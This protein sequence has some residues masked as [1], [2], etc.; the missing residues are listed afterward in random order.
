MSPV[1]TLRR[2]HRIILAV[3]DAAEYE[4][5][6][7]ARR[8]AF[9]AAVVG[10]L[11]EFLG[12]FAHALH[13]AKEERHLFVHLGR[14]IAPAGRI[15]LVPLLRCHDECR[16][17]L[18]AVADLLGPSIQGDYWTAL[19]LSDQIKGYCKH[20]RAHIDHEET[21]VF[22]AAE[23]V[24]APLD[25][26]ALTREFQAFSHR[27]GIDAVHKYRRLARDL[28][29]STHPDPCLPETVELHFG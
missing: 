19:S 28:T 20:M 18:Q 4:G 25:E 9:D 13:Q 17:R 1:D 2:E 8:G 3:L 24:L 22:P 23:S 26:Q 6:Q 7:I 16:R 29:R 12:G 21:V 11:L 14:R 5:Q 27:I 15:H 10:G